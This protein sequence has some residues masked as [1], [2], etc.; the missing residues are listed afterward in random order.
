MADVSNFISLDELEETSRPT[1]YGPGASS[2]V[3]TPH[4]AAMHRQ[5]QLPPAYRSLS[6][7]EL[8][9]AIGTKRAELADDLVIL[10]HH[11]QRDEIIRHAD[12]RGDSFK[13]SQ[14]AAQSKAKYIVFCG[15]YFMAESADILTDASQTVILPNLTAGCSMADMANL[16][17]V[18]A[19]WNAMI[20]AYGA[21]MVPVTYMNSSA[22]LKAFC[23]EHGGIVCTSSNA[24]AIVSWA[25]ERGRRVLFFP[26]EHL[27]RNTADRLELPTEAVSVWNPRDIEGS[28]RDARNA[29]LTVWKGFCSVHERFTVEQIEDART[30]HPN[31]TVIV[32]PECRREVV[33]AADSSGS[34]EYIVA[35]I[36]QARPG[37]N[38]AVGTE[39][40]LVNRLA[41]E[42]PE[43]TIFC[44]DPVVCP[45][46]TMYRIHPAYLA[47]VLDNLVSGNVVNRVAV[48]RETA[49][50]ARLALNRMLEVTEGSKRAPRV[51]S[52]ASQAL[53]V[54]V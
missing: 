25:F 47:W 20:E 12:L 49:R 3:K 48:D 50:F 33:H 8:V 23:G 13:L 18:S 35:E 9:E 40:N 30:R 28:V 21:G 31:C 37:T 42:H 32:H 19:A 45:C 41:A 4:R 1:A 43:M 16:V 2:G 52:V 17:D 46:S 44:L 51:R 26:D 53:A 15:V 34:T 14:L 5:P 38:F 10:G 22:D 39:V 36:E 24:S 29:L 7:D 11:Y 54:A 27:G 6:D